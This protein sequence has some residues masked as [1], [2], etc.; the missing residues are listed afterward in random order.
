M[1]LAELQE[2]VRSVGQAPVYWVSGAAAGLLCAALW[3]VYNISG[4]FF[5]GRLVILAALVMVLFIAG[6]FALVKK[7][8]TDAGELVREGVQYY[9]RVLL[10]WLVISAVLLLVFVVITI[11]TV[12]TQGSTVDYEAMGILAVIVMIPTLFLTFFCDTAA[13]FEDLRVFTS[14]RRSI[15]VAAAHAGAVF[16]FFVVC[17]ALV[18]ADFFIFAIIWEGLLY[19]KLAPLAQ[20]NET[21]FAS[22]T[23]QLL[24]TMIGPDGIWITAAVICLALLFIVPLLLAYKACFYRSIAGVAGV[25]P[26]VE[27]PLT[28]EYDSK[29]R[30]YK[31]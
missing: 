27:K 15:G 24:I 26:G 17:A 5:A 7:N 6:T 18:F 28:G 11:V 19:E 1:V 4:A 3:I 20:Y 8:S 10:P 22:V 16:S 13:V 31:Y 14:L 25:A 29:G 23:P 30:W 21:Q 2:A 12:F 9:F